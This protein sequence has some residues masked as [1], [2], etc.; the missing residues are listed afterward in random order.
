MALLN[1]GAR[2]GWPSYR[3]LVK[4]SKREREKICLAMPKSDG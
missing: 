4:A 3:A 2:A 1:R